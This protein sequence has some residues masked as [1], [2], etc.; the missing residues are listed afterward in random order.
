MLVI[1]LFRVGKKKQPF[2]KIVVT[3]KRNAPHGGRFV[4][5]VG[6][7]N[8]V[9]K[10]KA[11]KAERIKHWLCKGA[12]PSATVYN[13]LIK[14][15]ILEG[16]KI[17]KYAKAKKKAASKGGEPRPNKFGREE[18]PAETK[19]TSEEK[20]AEKPVE[21]APAEPPVEEKPTET[22]KPE[23]K[24]TKEKE[25]EEPVEEPAEP[26]PVEEKNEEKPEEKKI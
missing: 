14:E 24:P 23:E 17:P 7:L 2:F 26:A 16:K 9:T 11:L 22:A 25:E 15:K 21:S 20:K 13:L 18:K 1:R 10:E 6:F 4:E 19:L 3:D 12:Q 8:P 5:E